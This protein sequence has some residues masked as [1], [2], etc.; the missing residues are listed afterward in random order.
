MKIGVLSDTHGDVKLTSAALE[1]FCEQGV[2]QILHCGD[3]GTPE[4]V[5]LFS[6][7]PTAFVFGNCDPKTETLRRAILSIDQTCCDWFG[8]LELDG[9]RIFFLHGHQWNRFENEVHSGQWDLICYGHTH[10]AE[11]RMAGETLILNP[12]AIYRTASPSVAIVDLE[13]MNVATVALKKASQ[14]LGV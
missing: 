6:Q 4:I 12:G 5:L 8:E 11:L 10:N 7:I 14:I 9:K 3:I 1:V 13:S 2:S